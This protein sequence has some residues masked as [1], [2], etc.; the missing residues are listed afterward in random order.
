MSFWGNLVRKFIPPS[1]LAGEPV[2]EIDWE[3][4]LI[5][6]D[7]GL[8]L[9]QRFVEELT[10][11]KL[12]KKPTEAEAYIRAQLTALVSVPVSVPTIAT[13]PE[14]I[15]LIGVNGSG[16]TTTA[17]KLTAHAVQTGRRVC[18]GAADTFR[19]AAVDQLQVWGDR[20][21]VPVITAPAGTD[22]ASVAFRAHEQA[23]K[24][25]ADLLIVD[26]AGRLP[27]KNNLMLEIAKVKRTLQ[28]REPSAPHHIWLVVDGTTGNNILLQA[29]EFHAALQL[30]GLIMTK[31]DSSAKGG[32]IAAV[33]AELGVPTLYLG[34]GEKVEDLQKF[35]PT[36]YVAEFFGD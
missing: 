29:R 2:A 26:T 13:R 24:D 17:A 36:R 3:A 16:K 27:N 4:L 31:L 10:E 30:T 28:K 34:R 1:I 21:G 11:R 15:L 7:L 14:V 35:E 23:E 19:A 25:G 5:E 12:L 22:P 18:L 33:Q 8:E 20:L 6:A 9:T 32:M